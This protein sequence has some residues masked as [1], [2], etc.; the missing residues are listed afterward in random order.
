MS[1]NDR[2]VA[3]W[4]RDQRDR[5]NRSMPLDP[6]QRNRTSGRRKLEAWRERLVSYRCSAEMQLELPAIF[7]R[8]RHCANL[9]CEFA[10]ERLHFEKLARGVAQRSTA[11]TADRHLK[12]SRFF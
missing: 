6:P 11:Q 3:H 12:P 5:D 10:S 1:E 4:L 7:A 8:E 9:T 2:L